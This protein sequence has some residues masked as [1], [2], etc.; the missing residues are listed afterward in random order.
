MVT[1]FFFY[2]FFLNL[3]LSFKSGISLRKV[4]CS[5]RTISWKYHHPHLRL[6]ISPSLHTSISPHLHLAHTSQ[7]SGTIRYVTLLLSSPTLLTR[8]RRC[9][10]CLSVLEWVFFVTYIIS[11]LPFT[12]DSFKG[13]FFLL[14]FY[15]VRFLCDLY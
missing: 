3:N 11:N 7:V 10:C 9:Y 1:D 12:F 14:E 4:K 2:L 5:E 8:T 13:L 6:S 15:I